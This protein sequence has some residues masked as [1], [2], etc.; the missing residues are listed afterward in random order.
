MFPNRPNDG[1]NNVPR[2]VQEIIVAMGAAVVNT[3][4]AV[5]NTNAAVNQLTAAVQQGDLQHDA[6][7]GFRQLKPKKD[8]TNIT[9][10]DAPTL[11]VQMDQFEIDLGELGMQPQ[12]EAGYRQLRA[13]C[14]GRAREV[15]DLCTSYGQ[16]LQLVEFLN[17]LVFADP[18][19]QNARQ[20]RDQA[21]GQLY[22]FLLLRH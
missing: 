19:P 6:N 10:D 2:F 13:V 17:Q 8:I 21:G 3:N 9:A 20:A 11:M 22:I 14:A 16:G 18:P 1:R 7:K 15:V 5:A 12:T 4:N